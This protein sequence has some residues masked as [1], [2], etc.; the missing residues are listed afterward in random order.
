MSGA[1]GTRVVTWKEFDPLT[2]QVI[3]C[4]IEVHRQLGPGLL[5][6]VYRTC[7]A[8]ELSSVGR[9]CESELPVPVQYKGIALECGFR[10][11]LVVDG[12]LVVELKAVDALLPV[13]SAQL[14]TYLK[15]SGCRTG[16]LINFNSKVLRDGIRRL[17]R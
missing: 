15:L 14:L 11:D 2:H 5:E 10:M 4:A 17:A 13:H 3:G 8:Y 9:N 7:L 16:L 6:S 12:E 1:Q